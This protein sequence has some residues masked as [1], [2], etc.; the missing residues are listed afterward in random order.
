[1]AT[2]AQHVLVPVPL[3]VA[4][5]EE[6][7]NLQLPDTDGIPL[8]SDWH[9]LAIALLI[10]S[11][12]YHFKDRTNFYVGGNMFI[13]FSLEHVRQRSF[14]GPDFFY[15]EDVALNPPRRSW[16]V[17]N[18]GG[19]Y[20]NAIIELLSPS[21]QEEDRTTKKQIYE[22]TF[23]TAEYYCYDPET[24]K[25]EGWR[26]GGKRQRYQVIKPDGRGWLW[27][28]V[29]QLSLGTWK[30]EYL[31]HPATWL[32]FYTRQGHLVEL[33][34]ETALQQLENERQRAENERQRAEAAEA[35][36]A[37][38]RALLA[39]QETPPGTQDKGTS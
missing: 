28:D 4:E 33:K 36:L 9:R 26:L 16:I 7:E 31:R 11:V 38:L 20:P 24:E 22:R 15:V 32:R 1:M 3:P 17:W 8:E 25:L 34:D 2:K 21:T 35:E 29:L 23:R 5:L 27:S 30:G 12:L 37:R 39:Q 6:L 13:H 19:R 18:E 14:R 10:E